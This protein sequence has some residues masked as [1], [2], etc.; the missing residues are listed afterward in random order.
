MKNST[1][2]FMIIIS[3][4]IGGCSQS[5]PKC[6][7]KETTDL[8][9]EKAYGE[10]VKQV[11]AEKVKGVS[12]TVKGIRTK[13]TNKKTGACECAADLE[14]THQNGKS[15]SIPITYTVEITDD[16]KELYVTVFGLK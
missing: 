4:F 9:K 3:I 8:V 15:G 1:L 5:A 7:D 10:L 16:R 6:S 13:K 11:G 14:I 2:F 12:F